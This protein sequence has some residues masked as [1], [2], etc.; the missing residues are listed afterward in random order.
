MAALAEHGAI[1]AIELRLIAL[2][3]T[4]VNHVQS[5]GQLVHLHCAV[6]LSFFGARVDIDLQSAVSDTCHG[7][8]HLL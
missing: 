7:G 2:Q 4:E 3:A 1:Q 5:W 6:Q 8:W